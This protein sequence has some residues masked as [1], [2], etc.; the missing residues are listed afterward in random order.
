[1]PPISAA[2]CRGA[3]D[4]R[5]VRF[6]LLRCR[7]IFLWVIV[8][9]VLINISFLFVV[10]GD[11]FVALFIVVGYACSALFV[12]IDIYLQ[13]RNIPIKEFPGCTQPDTPLYAEIVALW[14][15]HCRRAGYSTPGA[16]YV[17]YSVPMFNSRGCS[18]WGSSGH[19]SIRTHQHCLLRQG[20]LI[21]FLKKNSL[22]QCTT[23]LGI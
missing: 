23:K 1:M 11:M 5:K 15:V 13:R 7:M 17:V 9:N 3:I 10:F 2:D 6:V 8:V 16:V 4:P 19:Y 20:C 22:R 14:E 12:A 18:L 21:N